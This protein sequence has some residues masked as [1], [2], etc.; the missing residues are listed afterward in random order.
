MRH[1]LFAVFGS[2]MILGLGVFAGGCGSSSTTTTGDGK[3]GAVDKPADAKG[4]VGGAGGTDSRTAIDGGKGGSGGITVIDGAAGA[5]GADVSMITDVRPD[6]SADLNS[7][8]G[9]GGIDG[10]T[11]RGG[12]GGT[13]NGGSGGSTTG[14][15][16]IDGGRDVGSG[17]DAP[18]ADRREA[19]GPAVDVGGI[20]GGIDGSGI[21][22]GACTPS[23]H[24]CS[25]NGVQTCSSTGQ[26]GTPV[27]CASPTPVCTAGAC[28]NATLTVTKAGTGTGTVTSPGTNGINC[29]NTCSR[30]FSTTPVVLT[31][32]AAAGSTFTGWS[33][34][35]CSGTATCSASLTAGDVAVT[36]TFASAQD[37][38]TVSKAGSGTGTVTSAPT[39]IACGATCAAPFASG[40]SVVLTAAAA[41]GSVF[42]GWSGG[43]CSG[44]TATCTVTLSAATTVTAT[45]SLPTNTLTIVRAGTGTGTVT[46]TSTPAATIN[47]NCGAT[48]A[49]DFS[50]TASVVLTATP[51]TG[52]AF[53]SWSGGGCTGAS[54]CT[55]SVTEDT[56]VTAN[57][58]PVVGCTTVATASACGGTAVGSALGQLS[59]TACHDQCQL[60]MAAAGTA[61]GCW[62]L[63]GAG[64]CLCRNG[65]LT[66]GAANSGGACS[67]GQYALNVTKAGTGTGNVTS[68]T[69]GMDCGT[70]TTC[71]VLYAA[72]ASVVLTATAEPGSTFTSWSGVTG[73]TGTGP[74]TVSMTAA[75]NVTATFT[76]TPYTLTV[77]KNATGGTGTVTSNPT[78]INCGTGTGCSHAFPSG[79]SV[80]LTATP[81]VA[82][83]SVF[84]HWGGAC[85]GT[86]TTCT[87]TITADA[88]VTATFALPLGCTTVEDALDA[89]CAGSV[90]RD[91]GTTLNR[92]GC[93]DGCET[94]M[95]AAGMTSGCWV[96]S[97]NAHCYCR[98]GALTP[99]GG[100]SP[101]GIC[102][103]GQ[104][105][106]TVGKTGN[107][108]GTVTSSTP[109]GGGINCGATCSALFAPGSANV[110]LTATA[111]TGFAFAGWSGCT[112]TSTCTVSMTA[113]LNVTATFVVPL[114]CD[115]APANATA[116]GGTTVA[117]P[118]AAT[119]IACRNQCGMQLPA[120]GA[121][122]G[123]WLLQ[124]GT[125]SCK[126][127][128]LTTGAG[129]AIT[130]GSCH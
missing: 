123:C 54:T 25:G 28:V 45:F 103:A 56:I 16:G 5:G 13:S 126:N 104:Y 57:F 46:S 127:G 96:L 6:T 130:A 22:T 118:T 1:Q 12:S 48:C 26:W 91:L 95:A 18:P 59:A 69:G 106:L 83:G 17:G 38:L 81:T 128:S 66:G 40:A 47:I 84:V 23:S 39:G 7:A 92:Q 102:N 52:S 93:H 11:A 29:G 111:D 3:D 71:S 85:S 14:P 24:Q 9:T 8:D 2:V 77:T 33:G 80:T 37:T 79:T 21:D 41:T 114:T 27:A 36:A 119:A 60:A 68:D 98:N 113:D 116:C 101:G 49:A 88:A 20:D 32:T 15:G 4:G 89:N 100:S 31:A 94:A 73:C 42:A 70:G 62:M 44:T 125:C 121:S 76:P 53:T 97:G 124:G 105:A 75:T 120:S 109:G 30:A 67:V 78:G 74:C 19:D 99:G 35:G 122:S 107:G 82:D 34:G 65:T 72:G 58:A 55:L 61:S 115:T 117:T 110:T 87:L 10:T 108:T 63:T 129:T 112:G 51:A 86:T 90:E 50:A 64:A 43:G